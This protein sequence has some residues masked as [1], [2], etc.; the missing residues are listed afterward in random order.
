MTMKEVLV[1]YHKLV[2][3]PIALAKI[4]KAGREPEQYLKDLV[5]DL[6][7]CSDKDDGKNKKRLAALNEALAKRE[8][9]HKS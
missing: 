1:K 2:P 9:A 7:Q 5:A 3:F 6:N 8:A 4:K